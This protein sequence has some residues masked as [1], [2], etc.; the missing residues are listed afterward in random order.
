MAFPTT[1]VLDSFNAGA[2]QA[3]S[4]RAGWSA[5]HANPGT[6]DFTT[7]AV[8]TTAVSTSASDNLWGTG[9]TDCEVWVTLGAAGA[10][11]IDLYARWSGSAS[12]NGYSLIWLASGTQFS[13]V[14]VASGSNTTISSVAT[15]G[16][17]AGD[18]LGMS[19][20]GTSLQG[21]YKP[22]AGAWSMLVSATDATYAG[23]GSIGV[24]S[25]S[26]SN[27]LDAFGGG[28]ATASTPS[29]GSLALAG[30]GA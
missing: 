12:R 24:D 16:L 23:S 14:R 26:A 6:G 7:D 17:G 2:L 15:Q 9:F 1:A 27:T 8:P 10:V 20:I 28:A 18:S 19:V 5:A 4:A 30:V 11:E 21:W 29:R 25:F 22:S 13:L 3:L